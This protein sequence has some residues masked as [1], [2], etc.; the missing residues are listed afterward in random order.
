MQVRREGHNFCKIMW[1]YAFDKQCRAND[2]IAVVGTPRCGVPARVL[3][4]GTRHAHDINCPSRCAAERGALSLPSMFVK[5]TIPSEADNGLAFA[6]KQ[7][8]IVG[9]GKTL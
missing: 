1:D 9:R 6:S 5:G 2:P 4:G 3:A 8:M 7:T